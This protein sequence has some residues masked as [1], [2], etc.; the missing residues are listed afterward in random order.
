MAKSVHIVDYTLGNIGSLVTILKKIGAIPKVV[1][2]PEEIENAQKI[3]L[4]GV[5]SFDT[6]VKALQTLDLFD[7]LKA[8]PKSPKTSI[9]GICLGMQLFA[10][11]SEEGTTS[12][13]GLVSGEVKKLTARSNLKVPHMGWNSVKTVN[14][15][16]LT[17]DFTGSERFYF[18]HSY[19]FQL[20]DT[21]HCALETR[22]GNYVTAAIAHKNIFG[23]QFHPEKSHKFGKKLLNNFMEI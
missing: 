12:G 5:G 13:L 1:K 19:E 10:E 6:A 4:P 3:I 20:S 15:S 16:K 22:Y 9:L 11:T 7:A 8:F 17:K 23:T 2:T 14:P 21:A 18:V